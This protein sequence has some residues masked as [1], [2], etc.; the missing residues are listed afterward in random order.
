MPVGRVPRVAR[1]PALAHR[2]ERLVQTDLAADYADLTRLG[3][4]TGD[5]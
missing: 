5:G 2:F 4:V 3:H 1:L